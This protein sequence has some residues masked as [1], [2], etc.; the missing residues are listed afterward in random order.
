MCIGTA[1]ALVGGSSGANG[2]KGTDVCAQLTSRQVRERR[3]ESRLCRM[4]GSWSYPGCHAGNAC[5]PHSLLAWALPKVAV[6]AAL[7]M[8]SRMNCSVDQLHRSRLHRKSD[9][10]LQATADKSFPFRQMPRFW[11]AA[12]ATG[13]ASSIHCIENVLT[14]RI[15]RS[16]GWI[17]CGE[18]VRTYTLE[19]GTVGDFW[20]I[21]FP[22]R[23]ESVPHPPRPL[24][25]F[26]SERSADPGTREGRG[27][28][29]LLR[30]WP[31]PRSSSWKAAGPAQGRC[32]MAWSR[33][34]DDLPSLARS[35]HQRGDDMYVR[36]QYRTT[37]RPTTRQR[38][39]GLTIGAQQ[40]AA[41]HLA[42]EAEARAVTR[43]LPRRPRWANTRSRRSG[44]PR[45]SLVAVIV[46]SR[47]VGGQPRQH[48]VKYLGAI[49][50]AEMT[51]LSARRRFW[52]R[53]DVVLAEFAQEQRERFERTL[54]TKVRRPTPE[55]IAAASPAATR[56]RFDAMRA[57]RA[58]LRSRDTQTPLMPS[59]ASAPPPTGLVRE[60]FA[61]QPTEST[62]ERCEA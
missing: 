55:E 31:H 40:P 47:R 34:S 2:R 17:G 5:G 61:L 15:A 49:T 20:R 7:K 12:L 23:R 16:D 39:A 10:K 50:C 19:D 56:A 53:A 51:R 18:R 32:S 26:K 28:L 36:W 25:L 22:S 52:D 37:A 35:L 54:E 6:A 60:G 21:S 44:D 58:A 41:H 9:V 4:V 29:P 1:V 46:E 57:A 14:Q 38:P 59:T 33:G 27:A 43:L 48:L 45:T 24:Q 8:K 13:P 3:V 11:S 42:L 62:G 30:P